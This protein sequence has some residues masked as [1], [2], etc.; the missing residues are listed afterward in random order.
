MLCEHFHDDVLDL[1]D[2]NARWNTNSSGCDEVI[3][4]SLDVTNA[5]GFQ[6]VCGCAIG[7]SSLPAMCC[8]NVGGDH[9]KPAAKTN[10]I[11]RIGKAPPG[12]HLNRKI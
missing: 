11:S 3:G 6:D 7:N 9:N 1:T 5:Y 8:A 4:N 2:G 10:A 12:R